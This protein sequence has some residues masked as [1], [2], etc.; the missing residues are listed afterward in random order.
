MRKSQLKKYAKLL[1]KAGLNVKKGQTVFVQAGLDQ[2]EFVATVVEECYKAGAREVYVE[3]SYQPAEKLNALYMSQEDLSRLTPWGEAK[4]AY[5]AEKYACRLFIESEDPDG[6]K[7][8]DV[9]KMSEAR[10]ALFPQ[11]KKYRDLLENR[12]Q[13]CIAAVPG[14]AWA[15]KVFPDLSEKRAIEK[16]WQAILYTSRADGKNPIAAWKEHNANLKKRCEYLNSLSLT[17]LEYKSANGTDFKVWLN[18]D[19]VF[20]AGSEKTRGGRVFHPN[21]PSEEVFTSPKAGKAEGIVYSTKPLSYQGELIENFSVRFTG[22]KVTEVKAEKGEEQLKKMVA[23]DEGAAMLGECAII[24]FDSPINNSGILFYNTLFDENASCHLALGKGFN[25]CLKDYDKYS[26]EE[27][28][29]RGINESMIHVDFMIGSRDMNI[30][31]V[32]ASGERVAILKDGN[33]A[34]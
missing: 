30:T 32:T 31:G 26:D 6:M 13:W 3:W 9:Q 21:I 2:P 33:W 7:G 22:G 27:C 12:H 18:E 28:K 16:L 10:K 17:A 4:W 23:M 24:P 11:V 14:A 5:K 1:V 20:A 15:K 19:G 8:V 34:F 25:E 29:R